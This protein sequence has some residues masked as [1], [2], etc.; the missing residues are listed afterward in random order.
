M[1]LPEVEGRRPERIIQTLSTPPPAEKLRRTPEGKIA[2][3]G[4]DCVRYCRGSGDG[5]YNRLVPPRA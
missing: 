3:A 1:D 2:H 5:L 4:L